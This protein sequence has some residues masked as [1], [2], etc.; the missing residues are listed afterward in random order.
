MVWTILFQ[1][2]NLGGEMSLNNK[3]TAT[4]DPTD[5]HEECKPFFHPHSNN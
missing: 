3:Y 1:S 5:T 2:G 4:H